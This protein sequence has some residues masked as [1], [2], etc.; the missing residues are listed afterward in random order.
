MRKSGIDG[1]SYNVITWLT[2]EGEKGD[3]A[4]IERDESQAGDGFDP[5]VLDAKKEN[6][7][8]NFYKSGQYIIQEAS[9]VLERGDSVVF[10]FEEHDLFALKASVTY[11]D[12]GYPLLGYSLIPKVAGYFFSRLLWCTYF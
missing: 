1:V 11:S 10:Q 4:D 2:H 7:T 5:S 3:L 9:E 8:P 6:R 12:N